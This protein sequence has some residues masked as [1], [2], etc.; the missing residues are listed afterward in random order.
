[1]NA[2]QALRDATIRAIQEHPAE[3]TIHRIEYQN[4]GS[5]GR[6]TQESDL[7]PFT[8]RLVP[9]RQD[10]QI[11][12]QDEAG[13]MQLSGWILIAP[14]DADIRHDS[15]VEDTFIVAGINYRVLRV[16]PRK[17]NGAI[18]AKHAVVEEVS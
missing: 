10:R 16:I 5:G 7:A 8:A 3:I 6:D 15:N 13:K 9:S 4:D 17:I 1:M 12:L 11:R 2:L 14:W 18:Y